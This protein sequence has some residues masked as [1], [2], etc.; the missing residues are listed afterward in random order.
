M[1]I[2]LYLAVRLSTESLDQQIY[3]GYYSWKAKSVHINLIEEL[4]MQTKQLRG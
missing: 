2:L 1:L 3:V 4:H